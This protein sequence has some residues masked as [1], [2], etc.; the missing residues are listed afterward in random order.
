MMRVKQNK[1]TLKMV[2]TR[3]KELTAST[4]LDMKAV[5]T[6]YST[7]LNIQKS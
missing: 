6:L 2:A 5:C 7:H 4:V 1:S 3:K